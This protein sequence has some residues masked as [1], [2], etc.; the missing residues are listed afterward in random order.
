M[1]P[2]HMAKRQVDMCTG[3]ERKDYRD[4][5]DLGLF[6]MGVMVMKTEEGKR[7]FR[8]CVKREV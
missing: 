1:T 5:T 3:A 4:R 8:C 6:C 2:A 7:Q